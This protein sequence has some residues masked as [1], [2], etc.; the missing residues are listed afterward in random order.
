MD[1]ARVVWA[2]D[3]GDSEDRKLLG[4]YPARTAWLLEPDAMPAK[5]TRYQAEVQQPKVQQPKAEP[6]TPKAKSPTAAK[7]PLRFEEVR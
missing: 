6:P 5:L 7:P 2:R 4:Y 3:L 1:H